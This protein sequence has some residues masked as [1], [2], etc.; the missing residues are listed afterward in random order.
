MPVSPLASDGDADER[1]DHVIEPIAEYLRH[2][3][4]VAEGLGD[5]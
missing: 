4:D 2:G 3:P 1:S 5:L